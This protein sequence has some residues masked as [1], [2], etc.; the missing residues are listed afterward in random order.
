MPSK[1]LGLV[2]TAIVIFLLACQSSPT[3]TPDPT[4]TPTLAPT[5]TVAAPEPTTTTRPQTATP[6]PTATPTGIQGGTLTIARREPV[7]S[8][9]VHQEFSSA[10]HSM[11][12][13][14]AYS[15]LLRFQAPPEIEL[16]SLAVECDLCESWEQP[17]PDTYVFKLREGVKWHNIAPVNGRELTAD[18]VVFSLERQRTQRWPNAGLLRAVDTIEVLGDY[19]LQIT[20]VAP[21]ADFLTNL[22]N[23]RSKVVAPEVVRQFG[24]L[25][26]APVIGTGPWIVE[27]HTPRKTILLR[28]PDYF[29]PN[30]PYLDSLVIETTEDYRTRMAAFRIKDSDVVDVL[31]EEIED[32]TSDHP[33]VTTVSV[34]LAGTGIELAINIAVAPFDNEAVREAAFLALDPWSANEEVWAGQAFISFGMPIASASWLPDRQTLEP[35]FAQTTRAQRLLRSTL[36]DSQV[37]FDLIVGDFGDS[38]IQYGNTI[39]NQLSAAGFDPQIRVVDRGTFSSLAWFGGEYTMFLGPHPPMNTPNDYILPVLHSNGQA[40]THLYSSP[41]LNRLLELQSV[42]IY[43][44]DREAAIK[45][46]QAELLE[47]RA[48]FMPATLNEVWG[49]WPWV[50][51]F[52][53]N[54]TNG[55][56]FFWS[57]VWLQDKP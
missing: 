57:R 41:A 45:E 42:I 44:D 56:Y 3:A 33:T 36:G 12:P 32:L 13:G 40:N 53:P 50:Q 46:I 51:D 16:P 31:P 8:L 34:P 7:T 48:R 1:A 26:A 10:L 49:Q 39:A 27:S 5:A 17:S 2:A 55:E 21:D 22:A 54:L 24:D 6:A 35:F 38:Y 43:P 9:D 14:L 19:E 25:V 23:A 28:N 47:A 29:E 11:G 20:L 52:Y 30:V 15:R 37:T 18:D 4:E